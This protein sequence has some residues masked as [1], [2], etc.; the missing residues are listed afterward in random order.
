MEK[1]QVRVREKLR[2]IHPSIPEGSTTYTASQA[3]RHCFNRMVE[4]SQRTNG[5][6]LQLYQHIGQT[7]MR[8]K[9]Q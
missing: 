8:I 7:T 5:G 4:F 2:K 3:Y 6:F 9:A 1:V